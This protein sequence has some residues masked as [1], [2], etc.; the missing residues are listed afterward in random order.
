[1]VPSQLVYSPIA[2]QAQRHQ[3]HRQEQRDIREDV[4]HQP[5]HRTILAD[6]PA[7]AAGRWTL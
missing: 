4:Q 6:D 5:L 2:S 3:Q 7:Y 1:M